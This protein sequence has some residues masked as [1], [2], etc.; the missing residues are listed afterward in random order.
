MITYKLYKLDAETRDAIREEYA[1][2]N[3]PWLVHVFNENEIGPDRLC[4]ACPASYNLVRKIFKN[5]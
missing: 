1:K 2:G 5:L 4:P 3:W